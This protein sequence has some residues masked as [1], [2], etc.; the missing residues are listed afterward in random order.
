MSKTKLLLDLVDCL[1]NLT[2]TLEE[3]TACIA[4]NEPTGAT[5]Q[6]NALPK[7]AGPSASS[8][9]RPWARRSR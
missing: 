1:R 7:T 3:I 9:P 6:S 5:E 4:G 2:G 8:S